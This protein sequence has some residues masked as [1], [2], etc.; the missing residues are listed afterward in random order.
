MAKGPVI[1]IDMLAISSKFNLYYKTGIMV[2]YM[3][4]VM[5]NLLY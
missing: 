1:F 3:N 4:E 2:L 5:N